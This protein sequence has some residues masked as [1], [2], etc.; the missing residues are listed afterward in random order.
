MNRPIKH[1]LTSVPRALVIGA[2][3]SGLTTARCLQEQGFAVTVIADRF[4]SATT[5]VVAGAL[6][7]WPPAVCGFYQ[8]QPEPAL[9]AEQRWCIESYRR[10]EALARCNGSGVYLRPV[11]FYLAQPAADNPLEWR[12]L[13]ELRQHVRGFRHDASLATAPGV[14]ATAEFVDAY[15]YQTP[16]IDTDVYMA[17]LLGE[18]LGHGGALERR[19]VDGP[20]VAAADSLRNAY[21]ADV[22]VNCTGLGARE[23][24]GDEVVPVR[25]AWLLVENDGA[26]FPKVTAAHCSSL[27]DSATGG[28]FLFI[29]P[30]GRDRLILGGMAQP[31]RWTIELGS[32]RDCVA[33]SM[34]QRCAQFMPCL[35]DA[36][37]SE[38]L[39]IRVGLRPFRPA[40]VRVQRE[41]G[42]PVVH[43]YGHGG[44]GVTL[45]WGSAQNA[46][47]LASEALS[48]AEFAAALPVTAGE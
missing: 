5:S 27:T 34:W 31:D 4:Q 6:W 29:V 48:G 36:K 11:V 45:S 16:L 3:V 7:E 1:W 30:R 25:G 18:V 39:E 20:L 41:S 38:C 19:R 8:M 24:A 43:N 33:Q 23:L 26:R 12:K 2:G 32:E 13:R 17:W 9:R 14:N 15:T 40:G 46:A 35:A 22:V 21:R 28:G 37:V 44:S 42:A 10:F 47:R